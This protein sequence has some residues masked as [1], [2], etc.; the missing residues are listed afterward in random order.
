KHAGDLLDGLEVRAHRAEGPVLQEGVGGLGCLLVPQ[1]RQLL[2]EQVGAVVKRQPFRNSGQDQTP[3]TR[4]FRAD[5]PATAGTRRHA[6]AS[7]LP[8]ITRA[9]LSRWSWGTR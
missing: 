4:Q 8:A 6:T 7:T 1:Q 2:L 3:A 5:R 9:A